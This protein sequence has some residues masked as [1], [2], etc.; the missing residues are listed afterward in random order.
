MRR[1]D[2]RYLRTFELFRPLDRHSTDHIGRV[3]S[4]VDE[5]SETRQTAPA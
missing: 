4:A 2:L 1:C 3:V 5:P